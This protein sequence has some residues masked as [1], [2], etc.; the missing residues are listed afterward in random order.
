MVMEWWGSFGD[1]FL[2]L[3]GMPLHIIF[4]DL[5]IYVSGGGWFGLVWCNLI[6]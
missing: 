5:L 4:L 1:L 6:F 2:V 3:V